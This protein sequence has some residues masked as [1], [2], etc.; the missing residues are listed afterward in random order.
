MIGS[1]WSNIYIIIIGKAF[2]ST[3]LYCHVFATCP[4][5]THGSLFSD[6]ICAERLFVLIVFDFIRNRSLCL[7]TPI[8]VK[9]G[10]HGTAKLTAVLYLRVRGDSLKRR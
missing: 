8:D 3:R 5:Y 4:E 1:Y 2:L 7:M 10:T 9:R 6:F